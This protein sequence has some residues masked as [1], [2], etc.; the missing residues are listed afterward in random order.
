MKQPFFVTGIG[1]DVGKTVACAVL[2]RA[3]VAAYWKPVQSGAILGCD[4]STIR[5]L[6]EET[7]IYPEIYSLPEP[8]SP[9]TA[10]QREHMAIDLNKL[11]LPEHNGPLIIEGAGGLMVP[12]TRSILFSDWLQQLQIPCILVSRHYLG[13]LNHTLTT[14]QSMTT[15]RIPI[16]GVL[17]VGEDND[18]NEALICKRFEVRNLGSIPIA[19]D[20]NVD[21]IDIISDKI[22]EYWKTCKYIDLISNKYPT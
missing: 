13:S 8:L 2:C 6:C 5:N 11:Q 3:L 19:H 22:L 20:V 9:H 14:L 10:A 1:T 17:F 16:A 18:N 7:L 15:L 21:F 4:S 12:L